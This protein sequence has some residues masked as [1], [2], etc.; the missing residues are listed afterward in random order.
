MTTVTLRAGR[1]RSFRR[2]SGL[3]H[4]ITPVVL[5]GVLIALYAWISS[6]NLDSI[7]NIVGFVERKRRS[8]Q[9]A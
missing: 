5:C 7:E 6:Q 4:V 3:R 2:V 1:T 9:A 8:G